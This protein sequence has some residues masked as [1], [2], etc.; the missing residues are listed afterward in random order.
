VGDLKRS[1]KNMHI[2]Y[3]LFIFIAVGSLLLIPSCKDYAASES[4]RKEVDSIDWTFD[5]AVNCVHHGSGSSGGSSSN[6]SELSLAISY[7]AKSDYQLPEDL[8]DL[9]V[10][11]VE[12]AIRGNGGSIIRSES[13]N[14]IHYTE[15]S[16]AFDQ[17]AYMFKVIYRIDGVVGVITGVVNKRRHAEAREEGREVVAQLLLSLDEER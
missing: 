12:D 7:E 5:E 17:S 1:L 3:S 14:S 16:E 6:S 11:K 2:K 9:L 15:H 10:D 13:V 8:E 4:L